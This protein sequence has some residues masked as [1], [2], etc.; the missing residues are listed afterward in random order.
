MK[1]RRAPGV[2][3]PF[4][5]VYVAAF[6]AF[7]AASP[8]L[9]SF[10]GERGLS[11]SE[12]GLLLATGTAIRLISAPLAAQIADRWNRPR[13][14]LIASLAASAGVALL[15]LHATTFIVLA[16][17]SLLHA[18]AL[19]PLTPTADAMAVAQRRTFDYGWARGAGS[20]AFVGGTFL[21]GAVIDRAGLTS[22]LWLNAAW[23][24]VATVAAIFLPSSPVADAVKETA[25]PGDLRALLANRPFLLTVTIAALILASHAMHDAFAVIRWRAAGFSN[26]LVSVLWSEAV[27][28]EVVVFTLAG[29]WLL[30][31]WNPATCIA[32]AAIAGAV[33]WTIVSQTLAPAL[34][35]CAE[36]L[37]GVTFALLHLA[38]MR[39]I[40]EVVPAGLGTSAQAFYG[41]VAAGAASALVTLA[42]GPLYA[43]FG[44][45]AFL[46]MTALC[47][48][49][50]PLALFLRRELTHVA[51][52][53]EIH[54]PPG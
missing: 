26:I 31:R 46:A 48:V 29:P 38:C 7:G 41:T 6:A 22:F 33:R 35:A 42:S 18:A 13:A 10:L 14:V 15:Y 34:I 12:I 28:A 16:G 32:L 39:I 49:A 11:P 3:P 54:E 8:F 2:L 17:V 45:E 5:A 19:A 52:R 25:K 47:L 53:A 23:L 24:A 40:A 27:I 30:R 43:R 21:S 44:G 37:H 36:P 50:L 9:P 20:A 1:S 4:L 51:D